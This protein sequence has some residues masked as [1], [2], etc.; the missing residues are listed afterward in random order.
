MIF[1][2][3][4]PI[5]HNLSVG[6]DHDKLEKDNWIHIDYKN[7]NGKLWDPRTYYITGEK[8]DSYP[9]QFIKNKVTVHIVPI[10]DLDELEV[11]QKLL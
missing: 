11:Q 1:H 3:E 2:I 10:A 4:T 8:A 5:W 6:L 7:K 9:M